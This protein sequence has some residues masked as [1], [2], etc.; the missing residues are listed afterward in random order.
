MDTTIL[1]LSMII[2]F[3]S[4]LI[5]GTTSFG[6][7]LVALPLIS[8]FLP[9]K[10]IVPVLALFSLIMNTII[11]Y[12]VR[13]SVKFKT[14][15]TLILGGIVA[16]PLG[17]KLL[18]V[19]DDKVLRLI[20]GITIVLLA[21]LMYFNISFKIKKTNVAY[22]PV[23]FASGLL[24]G[25]LSLSGPPI[26]LF[27]TNIGVSKETFKAT[28]TAYFWV[29]NII[30]IITYLFNSLINVS[31]IKTATYLLPAMLVGVFTGIYLS[32][33]INESVFKKLTLV[34]LLVMGL[35]AITTALFA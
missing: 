27:L 5:Q 17:T 14:I 32:K 23:G 3:V 2:I 9:L 18:M 34:L 6:F 24:G 28:L 29:L 7:C 10:L 33:K 22:I 16:T 20:V 35:I 8:L 13:K 30:T 11:L 25:S 19:I 31:V 15:S 12:D 21:G 4:G 26:V 1:I